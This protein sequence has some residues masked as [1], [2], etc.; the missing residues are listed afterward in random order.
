LIV[1]LVPWFTAPLSNFIAFAGLSLLA[2]SFAVDIAWLFRAHRT[3]A[4]S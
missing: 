4:T 3:Q 1:S 2:T